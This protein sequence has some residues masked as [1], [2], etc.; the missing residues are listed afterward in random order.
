M[1]VR[2]G[3]V[4]RVLAERAD[5]QEL[6]VLVE[7]REERAVN[8]PALM[9]RAG[10]GDEVLLNVTAVRLGLGSGGCHFVSAIRGREERENPAAGHIMK[11]RYT[12]WQIQ[13]R[14]LEEQPEAGFLGPGAEVATVLAGMPVAVGELHSQL[15]PAVL[16]AHAAAGRRLRLAYIMT[17]G[18]ALPA[19]LSQVVQELRARGLVQAVITAGHAFGGDGESVTVHSALEA[20][21]R[22]AR[23]EVAVVAMGPGIAGTG[24]ALGWSGT[25]QAW[26]L[27]AV[28]A[29]GG[30]PVAVARVSFADPRP[31][32][33]GLSHHTATSLGRLV[34]SPVLLPL[35]EL[36]P[37]QSAHLRAQVRRAGLDRR[38]QVCT[39]PAGAL[40]GALGA[41][42]ALL[43]TMGRSWGEDPAF[44]LAA[45]AAGWA[46]GRLA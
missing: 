8:Y 26:I 23:A 16:A 30:R 35:P 27:D 32:H 46:A 37:G 45:A 25:E 5:L 31:R 41:H 40:R 36:P 1:A 43:R 17:D 6:A 22:W 12:P 34:R 14:A 38:H 10:C 9:G 28:A 29:L 2:R 15:A 44:F 11:L 33:R 20:A 18:G 24:T 21:R 7:G 13:V 19:A 42:E 3:R 39:V 4:L